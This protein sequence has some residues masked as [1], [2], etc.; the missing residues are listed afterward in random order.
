MENLMWLG[1]T[2]D[3][4]GRDIWGNSDKKSYC[5][6]CANYQKLTAKKAI[7]DIDKLIQENRKPD[8]FILVCGGTATPTVRDKIIAYAA[9]KGIQHTEIWSGR[10]FEEKLRHESPDLIQRFLEGHDFPENTTDSAHDD[11][12]V[13]QELFECFERPAFTT[14]FR[15]EVNIP[16][17]EKAI[18]DTIEVLNTGV[19]RLRDGTI[20]RRISSR[21]R[22][23]D[24]ILKNK[25]AILTQQVI[26][27]RDYFV[28]L[29]KENEIRPCGCDQEDC[30]VWFFT[31]RAATE[32]DTFRKN[33][34]KQ[35][36]EIRP[37]FILKFQ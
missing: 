32:M 27:L 2:G 37:D 35:L 36:R 12:K 6:Q 13:V 21:H 17:F 8:F 4:G 9:S 29:K 15:S 28:Q 19:H 33:I 24:N 1:Q 11:A 23:S 18:T 31:D 25:L 30:P 5:Y 34:F 7:E 14:H 20:I 22:V 26:K 3:D 16:D 10:E